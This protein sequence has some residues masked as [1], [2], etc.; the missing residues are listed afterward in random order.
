M[1]VCQVPQLRMCGVVFTHLFSC[2]C[3]VDLDVCPVVDSKR[4]VHLKDQMWAC[5]SK[6]IR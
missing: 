2:S 1:M 5:V 4:V 6:A 3:L